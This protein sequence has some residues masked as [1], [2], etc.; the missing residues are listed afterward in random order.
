[1]TTNQS[2]SPRLT[3]CRPLHAGVRAQGRGVYL[4]EMKIRND[5]NPDLPWD[6]KTF[7][8]LM[9]RGATVCGS[10]FKGAGGK[11]CDDEGWF[12]TVRGATTT[13]RETMRSPFLLC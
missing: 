10:Y 6:G 8:N 5:Q 2:S 1:M 11:V 3:A 12:D 9:A 13:D 7:G 4:V